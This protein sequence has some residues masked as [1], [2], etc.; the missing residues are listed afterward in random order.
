LRCDRC[1]AT[2]DIAGTFFKER[3]S[4]DTSILT[5]CPACW[6]KQKASVYKKLLIFRLAIGLGGILFI[7]LLP[8]SGI[9]WLWLN[10]F[11]FYL[12][13][14]LSILPHELGHAFTAKWLGWRVFRI[15]VGYGKTVFK[16][17][18]FG[19]DTEFHTIPMG[20]R[21]V[22]APKET[23]H[24]RSKR[25]ALVIAG[26]LANVLL[27]LVLFLIGGRATTDFGA[28]VQH[29]APIQM[30]FIANVLIVIEN[31][32][33]KFHQTPLGK[34]PSDGKQ[35]LQLLKTDPKQAAKSHASWFLLES[36]VCQEQ[37]QY[38][39]ALGW[40]ERGALNY[41]RKT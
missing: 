3:K 19:F 16:I 12:A 7:Y 5:L 22:T 2:T 30:F 33:P 1:G 38:G 9:G 26:P 18:L 21:V 13:L 27:L 15:F 32:W 23:A 17:K 6:Q 28:L 8:K 20:G 35:L 40:L 10:I 36:T 31:L 24:Y 11:I 14:S 41:I 39:E 34:M 37:G 4:F 29:L 25:F